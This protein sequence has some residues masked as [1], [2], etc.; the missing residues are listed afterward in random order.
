MASWSKRWHRWTLQTS[1]RASSWKRRWKANLKIWKMR[2][3]R[4][5]RSPK[6]KLRK[7][8]LKMQILNLKH[9][10]P[11]LRHS[12]KFLLWPRLPHHPSKTSWSSQLTLWSQKRQEFSWSWV[13]KLQKPWKRRLLRYK[14]QKLCLC[15]SFSKKW[16]ETSLM[17][18]FHPPNCL[19]CP[20]DSFLS[21]PQVTLTPHQLRLTCQRPQFLYW[22]PQNWWIWS[23]PSAQS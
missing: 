5:P 8:S 12:Q 22:L 10:P 7:R 13:E 20:R 21:L 19:L 14:S 15:A 17:E 1:L 2:N 18:P 16:A 9:R 6:R 3:L 23:Q 11:K 4:S